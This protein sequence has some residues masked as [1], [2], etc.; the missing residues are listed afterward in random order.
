[1]EVVEER[2]LLKLMDQL[3]DPVVAA[4]GQA[5]LEELEILLPHH[6]LKV[7]LVVMLKV[8]TLLSMLAVVAV[9]LV[10][11]EQLAM[12]LNRDMVV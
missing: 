10:V 5:E 1:V 3:V 7:I 2:D 8:L 12:P 11:L 9:V 4:D 6:P